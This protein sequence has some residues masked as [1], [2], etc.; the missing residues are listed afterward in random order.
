MIGTAI[1]AGTGA[2]RAVTGFTGAT[3]E[4]ISMFESATLTGWS[5]RRAH[6]R[7]PNQAFSGGERNVFAVGT[8]SGS[9]LVNGTT[10]PASSPG[11][12]SR[13]STA[14][15]GDDEYIID[16][17]RR[18]RRTVQLLEGAAPGVDG[19]DT[20]RRRHRPARDRPRRRS[21]RSLLD[22]DHN[23]NVATTQITLD[24]GQAP[25]RPR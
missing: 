5:Y 3:A 14:H 12:G 23:Q 22:A 15:D 4:D 19:P 21:A 25:R 1:V 11:A 9:L 17:R 2:N 7:R 20:L 8:A 16:T 13:R 24:D 6:R 10:A 18:A